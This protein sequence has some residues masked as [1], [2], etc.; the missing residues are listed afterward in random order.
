MRFPRISA[1]P[2]FVFN[3]PA[4]GQIMVKNFVTEDHDGMTGSHTF[5]R[6]HFERAASSGGNRLDKVLAFGCVVTVDFV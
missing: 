6:R 5:T 1:M 2:A 3:L 4:A